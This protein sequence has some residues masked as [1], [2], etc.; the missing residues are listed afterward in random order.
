[1]AIDAQAANHEVTRIRQ[2]AERSGYTVD[3][4][5]RDASA[6]PSGS[7]EPGFAALMTEIRERH[8]DAVIVRSPVDLSAQP[9]VRCWMA[10]MIRL[11]G[12]ELVFV[13][14]PAVG[15]APATPAGGSR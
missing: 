15:R 6:R 3:R 14:E 13:R 9:E 7:D 2:H 5:V 11:A 1:M 10:R 8:V 4:V 12:C